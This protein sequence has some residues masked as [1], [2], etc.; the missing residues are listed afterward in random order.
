MDTQIDLVETL[1]NFEGKVRTT[2]WAFEAVILMDDSQYIDTLM[3]A[4]EAPEESEIHSQQERK[5]QKTIHRQQYVAAGE[6][7]GTEQWPYH[8]WRVVMNRLREKKAV[9]LWLLEKRRRYFWFRYRATIAGSRMWIYSI[10]QTSRRS[11]RRLLMDSGLGKKKKRSSRSGKKKK[12]KGH[13]HP[14]HAERHKHKRE[15]KIFQAH[16]S[17]TL[18]ICTGKQSRGRRAWKRKPQMRRQRES[19][20]EPQRSAQH[21][22]EKSKSAAAAAAAEGAPDPWP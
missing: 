22:R 17:N 16:Q 2:W 7:G 19:S 13:W 5:R 15:E 21:G 3:T 1:A 20:Q 9:F 6:E 8:Y 14:P 10:P 18:L 4:F 12:Q 11:C